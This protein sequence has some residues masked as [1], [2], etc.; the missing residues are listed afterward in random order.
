MTFVLLVTHDPVV[1]LSACIGL[2]HER[3]RLWVRPYAG[4]TLV[5]SS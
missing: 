4:S 3:A 5:A 2:I 1:T